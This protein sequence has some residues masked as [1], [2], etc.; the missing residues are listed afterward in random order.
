MLLLTGCSDTVETPQPDITDEVT[1]TIKMYDHEIHEY[2]LTET[3]DTADINRLIQDISHSDNFTWE[4]YSILFFTNR[5]EQDDMV[6]E[7]MH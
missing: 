7:E 4:R 3:V 2:I 5:G 1:W 6:K